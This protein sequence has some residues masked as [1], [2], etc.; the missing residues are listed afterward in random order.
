MDLD[1]LLGE[2]GVAAGEVIDAGG[3]PVGE[4]DLDME[5]LVA[6]LAD[7]VQRPRVD[8]VRSRPRD[9]ARIVD[10]MAS[11]TQET[12]TARLGIQQ[13]VMRRKRTLPP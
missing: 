10:E 12:A 4:R 1:P 11:L 6:V 8:R 9:E 5:A 3:C 13:P 7:S 2:R